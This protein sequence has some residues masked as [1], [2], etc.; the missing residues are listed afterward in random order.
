MPWV[1][2]SAAHVGMGERGEWRVECH[3]RPRRCH[4]EIHL[5]ARPSRR[6]PPLP[7]P[8]PPASC[9]SSS[10]RLAPRSSSCT[11]GSEAGVA[12]SAAPRRSSSASARSSAASP[13]STAW[14]LGDGGGW[15]APRPGCG[16]G[17]SHASCME[18]SLGRCT[19]PTTRRTW[20]QVA[21]SPSAR[22]LRCSA[23]SRRFTSSASA[24]ALRRHMRAGHARRLAPGACTPAC[25][26][27][28]RRDAIPYLPQPPSQCNAQPRNASQTWWR[29][30]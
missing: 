23:A 20:R 27:A 16:W 19:V 10:S 6:L 22:S 24:A 17:R 15:D 1:P 28:C 3:A 26:H 18:F 14:G 8:C 21:S 5:A 13:S 12:P 29:C 25:M 4:R 7:V 11:S 30:R 9:A 2:E